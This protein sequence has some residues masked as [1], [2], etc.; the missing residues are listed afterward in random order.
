MLS[1]YSLI[2]INLSIEEFIK[3]IIE[4]NLKIAKDKQISGFRDFKFYWYLESVAKFGNMLSS[5]QG[6]FGIYKTVNNKERYELKKYYLIDNTG[7]VYGYINGPSIER[8]SRKL[9]YFPHPY[10]GSENPGKC[11]YVYDCVLMMNDSTSNTRP[12]DLNYLRK[13]YLPLANKKTHMNAQIYHTSENRVD[14]G[15]FGPMIYKA[16]DRSFY[17]PFVELV[18]NWLSF[19]DLKRVWV[20]PTLEDDYI[21]IEVTHTWSTRKW[22]HYKQW[23]GKVAYS[24]FEIFDFELINENSEYSW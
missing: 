19:D 13:N 16:K 8:E 20:E 5:M 1:Y 18:R 4:A 3:K 12:V 22:V 14:I 24:T 10:Y 23:R 15:R 7:L 2:K 6:D 17:L 11:A 21:L 9:T